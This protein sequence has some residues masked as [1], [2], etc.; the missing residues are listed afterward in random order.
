[1]HWV[2]FITLSSQIYPLVIVD[3]SSDSSGSAAAHPIGVVST[4]H[5]TEA[6]CSKGEALG[7]SR[8]RKSE[9]I[10]HLRENW[11]VSFFLLLLYLSYICVCIM[12]PVEVRG[13]LVEVGPFL[14]PCGVPGIELGL[15]VLATAAFTH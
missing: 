10:M 7:A 13:Q 6:I 12:I 3:I 2:S 1:M 9:E 11:P 5:S 14:P 4:A 8:E 15:S